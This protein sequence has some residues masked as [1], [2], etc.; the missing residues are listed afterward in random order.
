MRYVLKIEQISMRPSTYDSTRMSEDT[1]RI[2]TTELPDILV[3]DVIREVMAL[4]DEFEAFM[5]ADLP[6]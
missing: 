6:S 1:E 3:R 5:D 2:F 4:E